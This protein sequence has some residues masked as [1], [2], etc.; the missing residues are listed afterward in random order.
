MSLPGLEP[1]VEGLRRQVLYYIQAYHASDIE[2][3]QEVH[4]V[5]SIKISPPAELEELGRWAG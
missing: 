4:W 5:E 3:K 1:L 2:A